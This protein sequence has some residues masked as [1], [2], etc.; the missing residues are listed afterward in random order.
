ML[1]LSHEQSYIIDNG[2]ETKLVIH[3]E[4]TTIIE[5]SSG[6]HVMHINYHSYSPIKKQRGIS[7]PKQHL[8]LQNPAQATCLL[9]H[10]PSHLTAIPTTATC[11]A[12]KSTVTDR[13]SSRTCLP[14]TVIPKPRNKK[15]TDANASSG[16]ATRGSAA[17]GWQGESRVY[18]LIQKNRILAVP[19]KSGFRKA[20]RK[21]DMAFG[22]GGGGSI[23]LWGEGVRVMDCGGGNSS[24][25]C[26][27]MTAP[28][29][30]D[31]LF[32]G[33]GC[34]GLG[35]RSMTDALRFERPGLV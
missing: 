33:S 28:S 10:R 22:E 29:S 13:L 20:R 16:Y 7:N 11:I 6:N 14:A 8:L 12:S 24:F 31:S 9:A 25:L 18:A 27:S 30:D 2:H 34:G 5:S 26:L 19:M 21:R 1:W 32:M 15:S 17:N 3:I 4:V 35:D 23:S